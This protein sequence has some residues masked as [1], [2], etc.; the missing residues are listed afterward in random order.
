MDIEAVAATGG[1]SDWAD[2]VR[3]QKILD[4][5]ADAE[6]RWGEQDPARLFFR[7]ADWEGEVYDNTGLQQNHNLSVTGGGDNSDYLAS[8]GYYHADGILKDAWDESRRVNMR[9]NYGFN[10]TD[11]LKFDTKL[12]YEN[13]RTLEPPVGSGRIIHHVVDRFHWLPNIYGGRE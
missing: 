3:Y 4:G 6:A 13:Q 12:S 10:I 2:P 1:T 5:S 9:L 11:R 8:F 7:M